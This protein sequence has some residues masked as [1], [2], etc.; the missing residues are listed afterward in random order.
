MLIEEAATSRD[1]SALKSELQDS[2]PAPSETLDALFYSEDLGAAIVGYCT[3]EQQVR[4]PL[5]PAGGWAH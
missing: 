1:I 3:A 5:T 4:G 2:N